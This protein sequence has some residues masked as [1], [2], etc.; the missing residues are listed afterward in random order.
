MN[1]EISIASLQDGNAVF[2][3]LRQYSHDCGWSDRFDEVHAWGHAGGLITEGICF[4]AKVDDAAVG[5]IAAK[6]IDVGIVQIPDLET[7]HIYVVP[8]KRGFVLIMALLRAVERYATERRLKVLFHQTDYPSVIEDGP[9][10]S[11][12]VEVLFKRRG[13]IGPVDI[14][15]TAPDF[16]RAGVT[17]LFDGTN[18]PKDEA[19]ELVKNVRR[20]KGLEP[21]V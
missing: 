18:P 15:Y 19:P 14:A 9:S 2:E 16:V 21:E 1:V 6:P 8:A 13:Y 5:L 11:K 10:N 3:L 20:R 7:V 17:Y 4:L 12:G